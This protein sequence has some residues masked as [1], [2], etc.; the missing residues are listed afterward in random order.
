[1]S[2]RNPRGFN[3]QPSSDRQSKALAFNSIARS[4]TGRVLVLAA[5]A[6]LLIKGL[7][8]LTGM[9]N[10]VEDKKVK[11]E[12]TVTAIEPIVLAC[13]ARTTT[14][15]K[16]TVPTSIDTRIGSLPG[17][18]FTFQLRNGQASEDSAATTETL[19]CLPEPKITISYPDNDHEVVTIDQSGI[20]LTTRFVENKSSVYSDPKPLASAGEAIGA[21]LNFLS[22][23]HLKTYMPYDQRLKAEGESFARQAGIDNVEAQ[24][25]PVAW[26][27]T[28]QV[29]EASYRQQAVNKHIKPE[30]LT[31]AWSGDSPSF[32]APYNL[33]MSD[34][35]F[36]AHAENFTVN[37]CVVDGDVLT[38][39]Q[40]D[41]SI[42]QNPAKIGVN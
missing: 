38:Q 36:H 3:T 40:Q 21:G 31:L 34:G 19:T 22:G 11:I 35:A 7:P 41:T 15:V 28:K 27:L 10:K 17:S 24:C 20:Q 25:G 6:A 42:Y 37:S 12:S 13:R 23:G 16:G 2:E 9:H 8:S 18:G 5:G 33:S 1:M 26:E 32:T 14:E 30:A 29:I 39:A 4:R